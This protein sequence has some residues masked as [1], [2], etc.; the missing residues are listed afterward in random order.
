MHIEGIEVRN[1]RSLRDARLR[2]LPRLAVVV[3]PN[4][5]GKSTLFDV[6]GFLKDAV[7][8]NVHAAVARRG[9]FGELVSRGT[10]G[11]I[12]ITVQFRE[13]DGGLATYRLGV[14]ARA[15][16]LVVAREVL[17]HRCGRDGKPSRLVDFRD[18]DG[19]AVPNESRRSK[20]GVR[21]HR[22]AY[23]LVDPGTL[24]IKGLGQFRQFP[25]ASALRCVIENWHIS[26][27]DTW[28]ARGRVETSY[29]GQLSSRGELARVAARLHRQHPERFARVL[30][31]MNAR[32]PGVADVQAI[33]TNDGRLALRFRDA[34]FREPFSARFV[35]DGTIKLFAYL[36]LLYAP[37]VP[38]LLAVGEPEN[39]LHPDLLPEL[40]EEFRDY[41][42][43]GGQVFVSTHSPCFLNGAGLE[44]VFWLTRDEGFTSVGRASADDLLRNLV[45]EGDQLGT[46]WRQGFLQDA[47]VR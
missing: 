20:K 32:V 12:E 1:Y 31:A 26:D 29:P 23:R 6:F 47:G 44:E 17:S 42:R 34:S 15:G 21:E 43:R 18:G 27:F 36:V 10:E 16:R 45:A 13:N 35:S 40:V 11:P 19:Y 24:A 3:G 9:G 2:D 25:V 28:D 37:A 7:I 46:L 4:G 33:A 14:T 30:E 8:H 39:H 41:A 5:A 38:R 22:R